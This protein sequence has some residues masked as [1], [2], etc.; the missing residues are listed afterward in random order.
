MAL[1]CHQGTGP[2]TDRLINFAMHSLY[3]TPAQAPA[4]YPDLLWKPR[5]ASNPA[6][7]RQSWVRRYDK[8]TLGTG[9]ATPARIAEALCAFLPDTDQSV[10]DYD[11]GTGVLGLALQAAGC[12][13]ITGL[14]PSEVLI[15]RAQARGVYRDLHRIQPGYEML[16]EGRWAA[17]ATAG[18][19]GLGPVGPCQVERLTRALMPGGLLAL[20]VPDYCTSAGI[21]ARAV[22]ATLDSGAMQQL[23]RE[24]GAH[25]PALCQGSTV[26]ILQKS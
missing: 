8:A 23:F 16:R 11:C 14:D 26:I 4:L 21:S 10:L 19:L 22:E 9:Y 25:L 2:A 6:M 17:I 13:D 7:L 15:A 18:S 1:D 24:H 3:D 5:A 12:T 20:A